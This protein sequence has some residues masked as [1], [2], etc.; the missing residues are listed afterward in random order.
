MNE[1]QKLSE[2]SHLMT[3]LRNMG[4]ECE[5]LTIDECF[6]IKRHFQNLLEE[7]DV[8]HNERNVKNAFD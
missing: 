5:N 1:M 4:Y 3:F 7:L 6:T 8:V 2:L